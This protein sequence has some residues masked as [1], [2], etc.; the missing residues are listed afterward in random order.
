MGWRV[1]GWGGECGLGWRVCG[2]GWRVYDT[3]S[4]Y[5]TEVKHTCPQPVTGLA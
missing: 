4:R 3:S 1:V 5:I 2:V